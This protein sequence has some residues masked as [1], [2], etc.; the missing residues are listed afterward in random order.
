VQIIVFFYVGLILFSTIL[1]MLP[2]FHIPGASLSFI[3]SLFTA[4]SAISVTGLTVITVHEV[5]N[6]W[7]QLF[8]T[9]LFQVGGIGI[10]TLGT[11]F[12]LLLGQKNR[13]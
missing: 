1:L 13:A 12:W 3:D 4:T 7:G 10:M 6:E 9:L 5:F 11:F 2:F 8:L